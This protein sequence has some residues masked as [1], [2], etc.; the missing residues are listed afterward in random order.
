MHKKYKL[1]VALGILLILLPFLG[2]PNNWDMAIIFIVGLG[3]VVIALLYRLTQPF[4][5]RNE[6]HSVHGDTSAYMDSNEHS[7][8]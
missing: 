2:F 3:L 7:N 6:N 8:V 1:I 4:N 5:S